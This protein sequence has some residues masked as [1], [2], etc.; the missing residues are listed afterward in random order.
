MRKS[1]SKALDVIIDP[2]VVHFGKYKGI[3]WNRVPL[4]YLH[5]LLDTEPVGTV[6]YDTAKKQLE[7]RGYSNVFISSHAA[8]RF[9]ERF[10]K[11]YLLNRCKGEGICDYLKPKVLEAL[12]YGTIVT[13]SIISAKENTSRMFYYENKVWSIALNGTGYTLITVIEKEGWNNEIKQEP[14]N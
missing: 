11:D 10:L 2:T 5:F 7:H 8:N 4:Q 3:S 12:K 1:N 6:V 9:T 13:S 14:T